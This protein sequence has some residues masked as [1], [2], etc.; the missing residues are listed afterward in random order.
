MS[1]PASVAVR[2][3]A[4]AEVE[5]TMP[6]HVSGSHAAGVATA[7]REGGALWYALGSHEAVEREGVARRL[8]A[9]VRRLPHQPRPG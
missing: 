1:L 6:Q 3:P 9:E 4:A 8:L 5:S 2:D 7:A